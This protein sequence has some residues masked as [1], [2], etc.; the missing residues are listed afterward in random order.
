MQQSSHIML[1]HY[2]LHQSDDPTII[3]CHGALRRWRNGVNQCSGGDKILDQSAVDSD[4]LRVS[5][6]EGN[7]DI[8][9]SSHG[10]CRNSVM[11]PTRL[12]EFMLLCFDSLSL[13]LKA[14]VLRQDGLALGL[15]CPLGCQVT[16]DGHAQELH[17]RPGLCCSGLHG[18][19]DKLGSSITRGGC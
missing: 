12:I 5:P 14:G 15:Q 11:M 8:M 16:W 1:F 18:Y 3:I 9:S 4:V 19:A 17:I 13:L 2:C 6:H 10:Q 7:M